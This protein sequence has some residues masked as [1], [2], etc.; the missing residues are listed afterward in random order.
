MQNFVTHCHANGNVRQLGSG[1]EELEFITPLSPLSLDFIPVFNRVRHLPSNQAKVI[2]ITFSNTL[3]QWKDV[4][5]L[6]SSGSEGQDGLILPPLPLFF[7]AVVELCNRSFLFF[8]ISN[9]KMLLYIL[10]FF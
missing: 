10:Y 1:Q 7:H 8:M 5:P 3:A 4:K 2:L 6:A 9:A